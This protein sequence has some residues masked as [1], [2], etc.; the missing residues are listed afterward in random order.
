MTCWFST[1][2]RGKKFSKIWWPWIY[3]ETACTLYPPCLLFA[4]V[5]IYIKSSLY[6]V[7]Q[8]SFSILASFLCYVYCIVAFSISGLSYFCVLWP[9]LKFVILQVASYHVKFV[10]DVHFCIPR[11][12]TINMLYKLLVCMYFMQVKK[13]PRYLSRST[14]QNQTCCNFPEWSNNPICVHVCSQKHVHA[15]FS[16]WISFS[17]LFHLTLPRSFF[18]LFRI[19]PR[20]FGFITIIFS[21]GWML[22]FRGQWSK[23]Q[24]RGAVFL[25]L[26]LNPFP[27]GGKMEKLAIFSTSCTLTLLQDVDTVI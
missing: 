17:V 11:L 22:P 4:C 7:C 5:H 27:R 26:W 21:T 8:N 1:K 23:I 18:S 9:S 19:D 14:A 3:Q 20:Y 6:V 12:E 15:F 24:M 13:S 10:L 2:R 16:F 25:R